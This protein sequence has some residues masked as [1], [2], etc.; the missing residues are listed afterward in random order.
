[1][2]TIPARLSPRPRTLASQ[3]ALVSC[4]RMC[5]ALTTA[6]C[7]SAAPNDIHRPNYQKAQLEANS[8]FNVDSLIVHSV[9]GVK[10]DW[11]AGLIMLYIRDH[12]DL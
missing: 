10:C 12:W 4:L 1:M 5:S 7:L 6:A 2:N 11:L 9:L 8:E 3:A